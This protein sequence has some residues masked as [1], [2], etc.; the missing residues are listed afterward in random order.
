MKISELSVRRPVFAAVVS[1]LLVILGS[2]AAV[3][4][5]VREFP[6]VESPVVSVTT[7]YRGAS[8]DVVET[9]ITRVTSI[10]KPNSISAG[11]VTPTPKAIDSPADPAVC[12][13]LFSRIVALRS[14]KAML[15]ARNS[16]IDSTATGIDAETVRPTRSTRYKDDAPKTIPS[17]VPAST[18]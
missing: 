7:N 18:D 5:P 3:R 16:V 4:L 8:S 14:P 9:K 6:D 1:L 10:S 12:V 2:L 11:I 13:M 17:S 15:I